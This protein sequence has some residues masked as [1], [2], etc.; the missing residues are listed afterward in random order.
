MRHVRWA[1]F[2][3]LAALLWAAGA[4]Q[5]VHAQTSEVTPVG[6]WRTIDDKT[7]KAAAVVAISEQGGELHGRVEQILRPQEATQDPVCTKCQ[8]ARRNQK[9][10]GMEILWGFKKT[11]DG[12]SDGW[13][14]DPGSGDVYHATLEP[15]EGGKRL[16]VFGYIRVLVKIGRSQIWERAT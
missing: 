13:I 9:I 4:G 8:G 5:T 6:T 15:L 16:K 1:R 7:G 3:V 11:S 12:W 14:L 2:G 10:R